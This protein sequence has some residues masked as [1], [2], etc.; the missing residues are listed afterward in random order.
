MESR[1]HRKPLCCIS[2]SSAGVENPV[3]RETHVSVTW[4]GL[5]K[6]LDDPLK[7]FFAP[8]RR[9]APLHI[10]EKLGQALA[11]DAPEPKE[12]DAWGVHYQA[13]EI[14]DVPSGRSG[15]VPALVSEPADFA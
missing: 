3:L 5:G 8:L 12:L 11:R 14:Q 1:R 6:T 15:R 13:A 2:T 4:T 10:G 9:G 7:A